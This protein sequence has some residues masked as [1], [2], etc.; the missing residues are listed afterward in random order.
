MATKCIITTLFFFCQLGLAMATTVT[1]DKV[2][3]E[4]TRLRQTYEA[5]SKKA[6]TA[7]TLSRFKKEH[8]KART[9][10][11]Q[12]P[13]YL[14]QHKLLQVTRDRE[15]KRV[16]DRYKSSVSKLDQETLAVV[17]KKYEKE[18]AQLKKR[19]AK[20]INLNYV[21]N[22]QA[23]EKKLIAQGNLA[24][25]LLVQNERKKVGSPASRQVTKKPKARSAKPPVKKAKATQTK[26]KAT[27]KAASK[28]SKAQRKL[29]KKNPQV[30]RSSKKGFAGAGKN[31]R[32]NIYTFKVNRLGSHHTTLVFK[33]WGTKSTDTKGDVFLVVPGGKRH[34]VSRWSKDN[35][36]SSSFYD[37]KSG[38]DIKPIR[39]DIS[40][41]MKKTGT[42]RVEFKYRNG[43][44]AF[45]IYNVAIETW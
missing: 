13:S 45:V 30:Y 44:E 37:V 18:L 41:L 19:S 11:K 21:A 24:G 26:K 43:M 22:L 15:M 29:T 34:K 32:N 14:K 1:I 27:A 8:N 35:L 16:R 33:G 4:L 25:A 2:P 31:S 42:Y 39:T 20:R 12:T 28:K 9:A 7:G 10:A 3:P 36:R 23:L 38:A 6:T 17:D 5:Q 40:A